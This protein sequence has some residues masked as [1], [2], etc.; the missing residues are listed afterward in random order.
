LYYVRSSLG[1]TAPII[2]EPSPT[3]SIKWGPDVEEVYVSK[4]KLNDLGMSVDIQ[5][6]SLLLIP[7]RTALKFETDEQEWYDTG[8]GD[9]EY[10]VADDGTPADEKEATAPSDETMAIWEAQLLAKANAKLK[11]KGKARM[12][13]E[14][15]KAKAKADKAQAKADKAKAKAEKK[16]GLSGKAGAG[17]KSKGQMN[18][19]ASGKLVEVVKQPEP[20][21]GWG[22]MDVVGEGSDQGDEEM[23]LENSDDGLYGDLDKEEE[24]DEENDVE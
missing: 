13:V 16:A 22:F 3:L 2:D 9:G 24:S 6:Y 4:F 11:E 23:E 14:T 7:P 19:T 8:D 18:G 1:I 21:P 12:K 17:R 20:E 5:L 15:A 10:A